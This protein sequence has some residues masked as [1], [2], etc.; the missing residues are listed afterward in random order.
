MLTGLAGGLG[1]MFAVRLTLGLGEGAAFP[2]ATRAMASRLPA[3]SW[4]FAQGITHSASRLGNAITPPLIAAL[5]LALSWRASFLILGAASLVWLLL[6]GIGFHDAAE[7]AHR[8]PS[9]QTPWRRLILRMLPVTAVDF[10]YGWMLWLFLNWLPGFFQNEYH[11]DLK[12]SAIFAA[13]VFLAGVIGDTLG[14]ILSDRI[15]Q[16]TGN[17][18]APEPG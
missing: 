14:G 8:A 1:S 9:I 6:W 13:G 17:R 12:K 5:I 3:A 11:Q 2:T 15:L 18:T 10:C 16:P 4:G 7:P